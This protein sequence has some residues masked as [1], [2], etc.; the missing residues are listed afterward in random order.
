MKKILLVFVGIAI[1]GG[2]IGIYLYN[3]PHQSMQKMKVTK[4][5]SSAEI[6]SAY[7]KDE[8]IADKEFLGKVISIT[9][10][11]QNIEQNDPITIVMKGSDLMST[12]RCQ[13]DHLTEHPGLDNLKSNDAI[14]VK[15]I[16]TGYLMDVVLER[17]III[18]P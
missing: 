2:A 17:C 8:T 4:E 11:V 14:T 3:K 16:C 5:T 7:Q 12:V 13:L 10:T 6:T 1:I 18:K 9:G 15:G